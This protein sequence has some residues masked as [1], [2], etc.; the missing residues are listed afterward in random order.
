MSH[1]RKLNTKAAL[2]VIVGATLATGSFALWP[3][4]ARADTSTTVATVSGDDP[5]CPDEAPPSTDPVTTS[6]TSSTTSTT[7]GTTSTTQ[8]DLLSIAALAEDSSTDTAAESSTAASTATSAEDTLSI[9]STKVVDPDCVTENTSSTQTTP[10]TSPP[11]SVT[12]SSRDASGSGGGAKGEG[13]EPVPTAP[14]VTAPEP[15]NPPKP[16]PPVDPAPP[17]DDFIDGVGPSD[18]TSTSTSTAGVQTSTSTSGSATS[19]TA[20]TELSATVLA[21]TETSEAAPGQLGR[22]ESSNLKSN[23][24][25]QDVTADHE[26]SEIAQ[27]DP[28]TGGKDVTLSLPFSGGKQI[29]LS[30][31]PS[32]L[33][34]AWLMWV[35]VTLLVLAFWL[36]LPR[37][38]GLRGALVGSSVPRRR[39]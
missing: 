6:S 9:A 23:A 25:V 11:P 7:A 29:A 15:T 37:R 22:A 18:S 5:I 16:P 27:V 36:P 17:G 13:P 32:R 30:L 39:R 4:A 33:A 24:S 14:S 26:T 20:K 38:R 10:P 35:L 21:E 34:A 12:P 8:E 2:A 19:A 31:Q 1:R 3:S 28:L